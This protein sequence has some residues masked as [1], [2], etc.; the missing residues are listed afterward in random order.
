MPRGWEGKITFSGVCA[1]RILNQIRY[2]LLHN[3]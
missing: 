2:S 3:V 1:M